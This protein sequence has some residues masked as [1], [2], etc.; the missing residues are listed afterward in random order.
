MWQWLYIMHLW[1]YMNCI[2]LCRKL[3]GRSRAYNLAIGLS[4]GS[5]ERMVSRSKRKGCCHLCSF[6]CSLNHVVIFKNH[7]IWHGFCSLVLFLWLG[8]TQF[9]VTC[10]NTFCCTFHGYVII[11]FKNSIILLLFNWYLYL[12][13]AVADAIRTSLGPRGMDKMVSLAS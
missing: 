12:F 10:Y 11:E 3:F 4:D 6:S 9:F 13:T 5:G 8:Y 7:L 1:H 2:D